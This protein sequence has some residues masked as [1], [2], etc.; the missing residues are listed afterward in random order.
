[1]LAVILAFAATCDAADFN[2][3][4]R[5]DIVWR[6]HSGN[7]VIWQMNGLAVGSRITLPAAHE[8]G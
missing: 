2:G 8:A 4:G 3:D 6:T 5:Q 1:L 7:P